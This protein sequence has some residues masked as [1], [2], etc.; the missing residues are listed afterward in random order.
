MFRIRIH[1]IRIRFQ[2]FRLNT[3][4]DQDPIRIQGSD[5][6]KLEK[7]LQQ[8]R[9]KF[10]WIVNYNLPIPRPPERTSKLGTEEAFSPSKENIQRFKT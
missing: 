7:N 1:L 5:D 9:N 6:Q 4:P 8:K 3:D 2:H 10:F